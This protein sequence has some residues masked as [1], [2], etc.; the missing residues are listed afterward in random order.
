MSDLG[1]LGEGVEVGLGKLPLAHGVV[2]ALAGVGVGGHELVGVF[3]GGHALLHRGYLRFEF[4]DGGFCLLHSLA[5]APGDA[6]ALL[7]LGI[8]ECLVGPGGR[9]RRFGRGVGRHGGVAMC[10]CSLCERLRL[11]GVTLFSRLGHAEKVERGE[12][13]FLQ[14][15]RYNRC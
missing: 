13:L 11:R 6:L 8:G 15:K 5:C 14:S 1:L 3:A 10:A 9:R 12:L 7:F 2:E 4:L